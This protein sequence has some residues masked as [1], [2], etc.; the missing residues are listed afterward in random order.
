MR[1]YPQMDSAQTLLLYD[2]I[3]KESLKLNKE[4]DNEWLATG[5]CRYNRGEEVEAG[6]YLVFL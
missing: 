2:Y 3:I 4:E 6:E 5:M 1:Y